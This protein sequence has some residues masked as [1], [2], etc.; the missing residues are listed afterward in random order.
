[1][2]GPMASTMRT[3][4]GE[5]LPSIKQ[6]DVPIEQATTPSLPALKAYA[7]GLAERRKR[8]RARIGRVLQPGDR[9]RPGVRGRLHHALDRLR[10]SSANGAGARSTPGSRTTGRSASAS[11]SGCSSRISTTTASPATRT[12]PDQTLELWKSAY[13]RDYRPANALALIHNRFGRFDRGGDRSDTKRCAAAPGNPV[14]DVEPGRSPT[15]GS[16]ATRRRG[17]VGDEAVADRRGDGADAAT[18]LPARRDGERRLGRPRRSSGRSRGRA[19]ST[20][21]RRRRRSPRT[22][23]GC[24]TRARSTPRPRT[25]RP[26]AA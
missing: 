17:Q 21:S 6:F 13:P 26:R 24:A 1:M 9:A 7:L 2:L 18:A 10:R 3:R 15:A 8:T 19:S 12:R 5:S 16:A 25:W 22:A 23:G 11:A 14:P 4:L 20:S